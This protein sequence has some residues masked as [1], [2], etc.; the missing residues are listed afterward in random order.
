MLPHRKGA[1][2]TSLSSLAVIKV[3]QQVLEANEIP[4]AV[5][6][7]VSGG[8]DVG[9]AMARDKRVNLVSFTGSSPVRRDRKGEKR[10][11]LHKPFQY[12]WD[13]RLVYWFRNDLES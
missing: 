7:T 1:P 9:E 8:A 10:Q 12:R 11:E 5:C 2:S 4:G 3:I 13:R 6:S